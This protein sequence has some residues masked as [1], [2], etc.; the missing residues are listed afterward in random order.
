MRA[1]VYD[2]IG[3]SAEVLRVQEVPTP[4]PG[5]GEV[6]VRVTLSGVNPTDWKSR[7]GLTSRPI[8]EFQIP[9]HD[10]AGVI[11]AVGDGVDPARVGQRVWTWMAAGGRKW[12]TA[13]QW[14]VVPDRQAVALPD[15]VSDELA[16]SLGVPAMTAHRCLFADGPVAGKTVLVAGGAG[17]V[18]HF[19][20]ELAK[21]AG[22][23]VVTTVSGPDKAELAAKAGADLVVNYRE[24]GAIDRIKEFGFVDRVIEVALDANIGLD[25]A[26][27]APNSEIVTYASTPTDPVVPVRACMSANVTLRFVL[28][29]GIPSPAFDQAVAGITA[30]LAAGAL[31]ELPVHR[32]DLDDIVAAQD[33]VQAGAV[34]KVVVVPG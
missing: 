14:S 26:V 9:H 4:D 27:I 5:P 33:A 24:P 23:R 3:A 25:L 10:A 7:S 31:T 32:Y 17:A 34:G 8:D 18:G 28:L 2:K 11:D 13:A 1:A 19:A 29:Y 22:A 30:A 6:R 20:I 21:H 12:G 15:G 16:V